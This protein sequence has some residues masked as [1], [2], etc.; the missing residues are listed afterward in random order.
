MTLEELEVR[1]AD[2]EARKGMTDVAEAAE[3]REAQE[4]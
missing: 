1:L 3:T 2:D 4:P